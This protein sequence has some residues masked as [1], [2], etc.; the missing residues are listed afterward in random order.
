MIVKINGRETS[1]NTTGLQ[2][3][4]DFVEL[5]KSII[6][7]EHM[8][9]A[10]LADGQELSENDWIASVSQFD[11]ATVEIETGKPEEYV[12]RRLETSADIISQ[13]YMAFRTARK[14]FQ[15]GAMQEANRKLLSG[16]NTL[17][18]FF[19]WYGTLLELLDVEKRKAFDISEPVREITET[20]K[21]LCQQQLYQSWWAIGETLEKKLEP[22]LDKLEDFCRKMTRTIASA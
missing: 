16:V 3:M 22:E 8:I 6:D 7:P 12:Y 18:E 14:D 19:S 5:V 9:T 21:T 11:G 20:C 1:I 15:A 10:L 17:R 2:R 4:T 13:C